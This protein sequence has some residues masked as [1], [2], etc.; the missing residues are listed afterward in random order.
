[1]RPVPPRHPLASVKRVPIDYQH[2]DV[3]EPEL[4]TWQTIRQNWLW[5]IL[6]F[7]VGYAVGTYF[8]QGMT[9]RFAEIMKHF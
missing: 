7:L 9:T 4:S 1:M 3:Y 8:G 2:P 5:L 6:L